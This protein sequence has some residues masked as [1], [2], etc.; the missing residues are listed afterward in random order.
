MHF[1]KKLATLLFIVVAGI[2]LPFTF[3]SGEKTHVCLTMIVRNEEKIIERCLDS[4]KKT[5]DCVSI[6]DTGSTD[7]TVLII[8]QY[9]KK[10]RIPGKVHR[11]SWKNFGH[12]RTLSLRSAQNLL[13]ELGFSLRNTFLLLLDADMILSVGSDFDK[14]ALKEDAYLVLQKNSSQSYYN[15][16][17]VRSSLPWQCVGVTHEYW[18]CKKPCS[19]AKL[20]SLSI[21]DRDDGGSKSDKFERDV[22]LLTQGLQDE[23]ENERYMF[24]LAQSYKGLKN[25]DE[26]I[27]W[28]KERIEKGG[29]NEEVWYSKLMLGECFEDQGQ[30]DQALACYLDAYQ[31]NPSRAESLY[32]I[33]RF[34]RLKNQNHL[35]YLF[36]KHGSQIPY[37]QNQILFVTHPVYDYLFD[38]ELSIA[39]Y[40][41]PFKE[42]GYAAANRLILKKNVPYHIKEQA[43]KNILFYVPNLKNAKYQSIDIELPPIH[44]GFSAHF[45]PM[46]PSILKTENGYDVI[47]RTV[48]YMQIGAKH[49]QSLDLF[50]ITNTTRT[51]NFFVK[52]DRDFNILSQKE[53]IEELPRDRIQSRRIEGLED[54]RM[55]KF[56]NSIWFTCTTLD[57]N[58]TGKPQISLCKLSDNPS[59]S[60]IKVESLLPLF[61]PNPDRCEKNWLPFIKDEKLHLIYSFD[62]FI[63]YRPD[64]KKEQVMTQEIICHEE[65]PKYDFS[66][67]SGSAPPIKFDGGYLLLVHETVY[68]EQRNYLHRFVYL[69]KDL[70]LKQISKP[71]IF[72][73]NG[74]EYC[75]GM[76]IDHSAKNLIMA[77]GIEDREAYLCT[78]NLD[79]VRAMLEIQLN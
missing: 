40:Y 13:Q 17:L 37:P 6:C 5:V 76:T 23:P 72:L 71:F 46:N 29:W 21:D 36:S 52:Y 35:A 43:Y 57:T 51:R 1:N 2:L 59:G 70:N 19:E 31:F 24:Y 58:P 8:E 63:I 45:N 68:N 16:R 48:N 53:I 33:S 30:W 79:V 56:K 67:F 9:L 38:E 41:T 60:L 34:Y 44:E 64:V 20:N 62:P 14:N 50:D 66:R 18:S 77:V 54:C 11:H 22:K 15:T 61:G 73:H 26:A 49:F 69:D 28:Y 42:E 74:I 12:N 3:L 55:F 7:N 78:V 75:C 32:H 10:N 39:S 25:Y 47:C 65:N 27:K 4:I